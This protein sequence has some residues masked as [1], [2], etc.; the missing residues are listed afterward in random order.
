MSVGYPAVDGSFVKACKQPYLIDRHQLAVYF[1]LI[2]IIFLTFSGGKSAEQ[3]NVLRERFALE[4]PSLYNN[5]GA[6]YLSGQ[7]FLACICARNNPAFKSI[8]CSRFADSADLIHLLLVHNIRVFVKNAEV[9]IHCKK[10]LAIIY[11]PIIL[12]V[13]MNCIL[14]KFLASFLHFCKKN[15]ASCKIFFRFVLCPFVLFQFCFNVICSHCTC[16]INTFQDNVLLRA[17]L[18][19]YQ[20]AILQ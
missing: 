15:I 5:A 8:S 2:V 18:I 12:L 4:T 19:V 14:A 20:D 7:R 17:E 9:K 3:R 13:F 6:L 1:Q 11:L 10:L 16:C